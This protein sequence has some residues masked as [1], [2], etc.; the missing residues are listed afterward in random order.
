MLRFYVVLA[1]GLALSSCSTGPTEA[2]R[3]AD[4]AASP[5]CRTTRQTDGSS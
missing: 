5:Q 4:A 2:L 3:S 1:T